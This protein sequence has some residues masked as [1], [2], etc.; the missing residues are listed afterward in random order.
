MYRVWLILVFPYSYLAGMVLINVVNDKS[1][2]SL[3]RT[4]GG[5][6][7]DFRKKKQAKNSKTEKNIVHGI[8]CWK[9]S[10]T[11]CSQEK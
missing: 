4:E 6:M 1:I 2:Q 3:N 8:K 11:V 5:G 10:Y 9:K 7:G